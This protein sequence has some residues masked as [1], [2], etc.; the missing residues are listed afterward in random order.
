MIY[1]N[2][3]LRRE[4]IRYLNEHWKEDV[5]SEQ[6]ASEFGYTTRYFNKKFR[7]IFS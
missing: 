1:T 5:S 2:E 7:E 4:V 3:Q 6:I